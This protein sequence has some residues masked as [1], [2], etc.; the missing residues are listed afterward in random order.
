MLR[1]KSELEK[2]GVLLSTG[3][4]MSHYTTMRMGPQ[5]ELVVFPRS[6]GELIS[7]LEILNA[8]EA[9][10]IVLGGGSN[11]ILGSNLDGVVISTKKMKGVLFEGNAGVVVEAGAVL[12]QVIKMCLSADLI[13]L[14]FAAGIP[15]TVGGGV[16]MNAGANGGEMRDVIECVWIWHEGRET[17]L[18]RDEVGFGYRKSMLPPGSVV[19]KTRLRLRYGSGRDAGARVRQYLRRRASTQP[20]ETANSG[21]VFKNPPEIPAGRLLEELGFKG[22]RIGNACFS[23]VHANFIVN[24]GGAEFSDV[25]RLIEEA[26]R[27]AFDRR[28]ILLETEVKILG[29]SRA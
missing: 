25:I 27:A 5:A 8:L 13:G 24:L 14:E 3:F 16:I 18:S 10:W 12:G 29:E 7:V 19:T 22:Y 23:H 1:V 21:C 11:V 9:K 6:S 28:G 26:K 20:I 17:E 4:P 2:K 15:G